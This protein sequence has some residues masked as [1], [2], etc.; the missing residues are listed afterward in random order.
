MCQSLYVQF[1]YT[2]PGNC[3]FLS[4]NFTYSICDC[5]L[6][7]VEREMRADAALHNSTDSK[8]R[9]GCIADAQAVIWLCICRHQCQRGSAKQCEDANVAP[10]GWQSGNHLIGDEQ[11]CIRDPLSTGWGKVFQVC[12]RCSKRAVARRNLASQ[13]IVANDPGHI[14][15][16]KQQCIRHLISNTAVEQA[17]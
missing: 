8:A 11:R 7:C 13:L 4:I 16:Q 1:K 6:Y 10:S 2:K 14:T 9:K 3:E 5:S 15:V 12:G 17:R